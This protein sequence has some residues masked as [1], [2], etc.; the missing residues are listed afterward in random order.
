MGI[1]RIRADATLRYRGL[2][3]SDGHGYSLSLDA[4][5]LGSLSG[6]WQGERLALPWSETSA[7]YHPGVHNGKLYCAMRVSCV[8]CLHSVPLLKMNP[9]TNGF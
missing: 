5:L 3:G 9:W 4:G 2:S 1:D 8:A 7:T 6:Q